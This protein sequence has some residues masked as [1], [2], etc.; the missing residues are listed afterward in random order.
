MQTA[1]SIVGHI[2]KK[3]FPFAFKLY[4]NISEMAERW[5]FDVEARLLNDSVRTDN[6]SAENTKLY[7]KLRFCFSATVSLHCLTGNRYC[8][9]RRMWMFACTPP[10]HSSCNSTV[11]CTKVRREKKQ[12]HKMMWYS[13]L[14]HIFF[15]LLLLV[16]Q[17]HE[18][19]SFRTL[20]FVHSRTNK[21][22]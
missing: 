11:E 17:C 1:P 15:F 13:N 7:Y 8:L 20:F 3:G 2:H 12:T 16:V 21:W 10:Q 22:Q 6:N 5:E 18:T 4:Q 14:K 19:R 9:D